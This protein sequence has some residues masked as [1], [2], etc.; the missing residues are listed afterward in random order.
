MFLSG[1]SR[2]KGGI[3]C[4]NISTI[5][6]VK[7]L[8]KKYVTLDLVFL[9]RNMIFICTLEQ[10]TDCLIQIVKI[11]QNLE[12]LEQAYRSAV[13]SKRFILVWRKVLKTVTCN[14]HQIQF[15]KALPLH[16]FVNYYSKE[17]SR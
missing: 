8:N 15:C 11:L 2:F 7:V 12:Y 3:E 4:D 6:S 5:S 1:T 9:K 14:V 16:I 17:T 13:E 10:L